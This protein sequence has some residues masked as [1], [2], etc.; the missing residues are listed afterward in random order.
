MALEI[1][2]STTWISDFEV[3]LVS[4][5]GTVSELLGD[6]IEGQ[7]AQGNDFSGRWTFES[8]E[9]RGELSNGT[10][11]VHLVDDTNLDAT[12]V[13]DIN[14]ITYV[15]SATAND[16]YVFTDEFS[17]FA[18]TAGH[19]TTLSDTD[20]GTDTVNTSALSSDT[21]IR[22]TGG[23]TSII[24]GVNVA[25]SGSTIENAVTGD[26]NDRISGNN[27]SNHLIGGRGNDFLL[28]GHGNDILEGGVGDD[29]LHGYYGDDTFV[30]YRGDGL[31]SPYTV[32]GSNRGI[33][34][35]C[36]ASVWGNDTIVL[37]DWNP[38]D[39]RMWVSNLYAAIALP[40]G[41]GSNTYIRIETLASSFSG[42]D[43]IRQIETIQFKDGTKWDLTKGLRLVDTDD[44]HDNYGS[45][46]DDFIDGKGGNDRIWGH[47]GKDTIYG[48]AGNDTLNGGSGNDGL[49]GGSGADTLNGGA[50]RDWVAYWTSNAAVVVDLSDGL[51]ESGGHAQGDVLLG[52]ETVA[53]SSFGDTLTGDAGN[54]KLNGRGGND[55]LDGRAGNDTL[56][57][58]AG[59]DTFHF[60]DA[61]DADTIT[62]FE[63]GLDTIAIASTLAANFAALT[64]LDSGLDALVQFGTNTITLNNFDHALLDSGD[65]QFV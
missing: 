4:P 55:Q 60:A 57:G 64:I 29:E 27:L 19:A 24:D 26:G 43:L 18:G 63:D 30:Y 16:R 58:G 65:F 15:T 46:L 1:S 12:T 13:S 22:L 47:D 40:D 14:L 62:D 31:T 51:A 37:S 32:F 38:D 5:D 56:I 48:G 36:V 3:Y 33:V 50:G 54:N 2:F 52:I 23:Q 9:F 53:G 8:Q 25:M 61:G 17:T 42:A 45:D 39:I 28:G 44:G 7:A 34:E 41:N 35:N 11:Q 49:I 6:V 20:G 21:T 59:S 10:W